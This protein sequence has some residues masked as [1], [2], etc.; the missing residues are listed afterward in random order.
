MNAT[1]LRSIQESAGAG[2]IAYGSPNDHVEVVDS[3]G[4]FE[5]EYAALRKGVGVLDMPQRGSIEIRGSERLIF[6]Q[7]ML[8]NVVNLPN[9][10]PF[11]APWAM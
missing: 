6:L 9:W 3:F 4:A 2:F 7:A 10:T 11:C 1:P 5:A 8:T